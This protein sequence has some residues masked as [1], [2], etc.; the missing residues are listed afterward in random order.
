MIFAINSR[1]LPTYV[2][3][4]KCSISTTKSHTVLMFLFYFL[5]QIIR[6]VITFSQFSLVSRVSLITRVIMPYFLIIV[7]LVSVQ[8][9]ISKKIST[10]TMKGR[11][12]VEE[13]DYFTNFWAVRIQGGVRVAEKVAKRLR[14]NFMKS[15]VSNELR[16]QGFLD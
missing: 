5:N 16:D 7:I 3:M 12:I 8:N 11:S 14:F 15:V 13:G 4:L 9:A 1:C 6:L 2:G 10:K